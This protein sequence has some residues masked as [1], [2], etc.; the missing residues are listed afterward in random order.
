[1]HRDGT[2]GEPAVSQRAPGPISDPSR[3]SRRQALGRI[4]AVASAGAVAWVVPEILTVKPAAGAT[5]SGP[6]ASTGGTGGGPGTGGTGGGPGTGGTGGGPGTGGTGGGPGTSGGPGTGGGPGAGGPATSGT[7]TNG[8][9]TSGNGTPT[10]PVTTTAATTSPLGALASTGFNL[11]RDAE[12]GAALIAGGWAMQYWASRTQ[13][14]Q[15][16]RPTS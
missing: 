9:A 11:Q 8:T 16:E 3:I 7:T 1:M 14:E 13:K 12:V 5:L 15:K 4:S 2:Q 6:P 10:K